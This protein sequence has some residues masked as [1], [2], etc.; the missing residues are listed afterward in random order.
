[1]VKRNCYFQT[2]KAGKYPA[3]SCFCLFQN[4]ALKLTKK[5]RP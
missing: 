5:R 2:K 1:M 3:F 4:V